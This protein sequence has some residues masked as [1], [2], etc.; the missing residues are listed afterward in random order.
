[1]GT[2]L[3]DDIA[4]GR[5]QS[6]ARIDDASLAE[7]F[8]VSRTPIREA[9]LRLAAS[10]LV[11]LRPHRGAIVSS[12]DPRRLIEM[13]E[14]M[15]E[16]EAMCGRLVARRLTPDTEA[17]MAITLRKCGEAERRVRA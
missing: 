16:L 3:G 17:A 11:E 7:R 9:L 15:A 2:Q 13:F 4:T 5:Y 6:R 12:P 10:G 1:M 8:G 14:V